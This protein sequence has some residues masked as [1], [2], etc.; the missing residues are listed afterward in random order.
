M[1][2]T[3]VISMLLLLLT[4]SVQADWFSHGDGGCDMAC[5]AEFTG[6]DECLCNGPEAPRDSTPA[7]PPAELRAV[8]PVAT[9]RGEVVLNPP[10]V[11]DSGN[12]GISR[13]FVHGPH[14]P[15]V[16]LPVLFCS[17]LL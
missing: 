12:V 6:E 9:W 8:C 14:F 17:Y 10:P 2:L 13:T 15:S 16:G 1:R 7:L 4:Q 5:C 11:L 3:C